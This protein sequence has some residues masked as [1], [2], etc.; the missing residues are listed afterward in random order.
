MLPVWHILIGVLLY[1][2]LIVINCHSLISIV[3]LPICAATVCAKGWSGVT[4]VSSGYFGW[5]VCARGHFT[6]TPIKHALVEHF[7][8][9]QCWVQGKSRK[10]CKLAMLLLVLYTTV[11]VSVRQIGH[12]W[13]ESTIGSLNVIF[14]EASF[15]HKWTS[16]QV[17]SKQH[18]TFRTIDSLAVAKGGPCSRRDAPMHPLNIVTKSVAVFIITVGHCQIWLELASF[19]GMPV[20]MCRKLSSH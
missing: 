10:Y 7:L 15:E 6:A 4:N 19:K 3:H 17:K 16:Q 1:L 11:A 14:N 5:C 18:L 12:L 8:L 9:T 20:A 13:C 2:L